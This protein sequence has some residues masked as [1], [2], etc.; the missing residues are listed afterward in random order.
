M[1]SQ[2]VDYAL[3]AVVYLA[4]QAPQSQT[5]SQIARVTKVPPAYLAKLLQALNRAGIVQSLR[6]VKGG[7][8][9]AKPADQLTIL[10]VVTAVDPIHRITKCPL[11]LAAHGVRLCPLHRRLD[12]ALASVEEAFGNTTLADLL[13]EPT[14]SVP[15]CNFPRVSIRPAGRGKHPNPKS[16]S[17][18]D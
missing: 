15:L 12:G 16:G 11:G 18:A 1:L 5:T 14:T 6:G 7:M 13:A 17:P 2:T 9:L 3:R 10:E 4:S 8:A